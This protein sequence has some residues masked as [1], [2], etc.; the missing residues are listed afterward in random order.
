MILKFWPRWPRK[1]PL[2]L[3]SLRGCWGLEIV[4]EVTEVKTFHNRIF[5]VFVFDKISKGM[6]VT[7]EKE[8][9]EYFQQL[10]FWNQ[11]VLLIKMHCRV[12]YLLDFDFKIFSCQVWACILEVSKCKLPITFYTTPCKKIHGTCDIFLLF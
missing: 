11:C 7:I 5:V 10:D 3:S 9:S 4:F 2:N 1:R 8:P 12:H 6:I